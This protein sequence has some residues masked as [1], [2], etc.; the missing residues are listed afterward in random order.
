M[1]ASNIPAPISW[2]PSSFWDGNDGLWNTFVVQVGTPAQDFRV[3]PSTAGQELWIPVPD[4]CTSIS[5]D[6]T[7]Y[8]GYLRGALPVNGVNSSGFTTDD[9]STWTSN[10]IFELN[11]QEEDLGYG[12]N[13]LYGFDTVVWGNSS[14]SP[15]LTQQV[16][17]G[18]ADP[19]WWLGQVGLGPKPI[20]FTTFNYPIPSYLSNLVN[21][22]TIASHSFAYTAGAHHRNQSS[23]SLTLGGYDTNRFEAP[24]ISMAMNGDNS[25]PLQVGVQRIL[26][27]NTLDGTVNLLPTAI[28]HFIDSSV[29]HMWL[30]D[31][32]IDAFV[33]AFGLTYDNETD[34]F[35]IND[36][37]RSQM[38]DLNPTITFVLGASTTG[39]ATD[40]V[41]IELP[42]AALDLQASYP[43][44]ENATNYFPIRRAAN[45]TQY[46]IGRTFLQEAYLIADFE[47]SNF[48]VA[49]AS[50]DNMDT[51]HLVAIQQPTETATP[52]PTSTP[53]ASGGLSGGAIGGIV[54]GAVAGVAIIVDSPGLAEMESPGLA[55]MESPAMRSEV[56]GGT[57]KWGALGVQEL[58]TLPVGHESGLLVEAPGSEGVRAELEGEGGWGRK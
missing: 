52:S 35:L 55:E 24:G 14:D 45:D 30:P 38:L 36:T 27:A 12:G 19:D 40:S 2:A 44:Y 42:Y 7:G 43:F 50:F 9:S 53:E 31:D 8:C 17:A 46:T 10:G 20:N 15:N 49:R 21:E 4:G 56:D 57:A 28:Y 26:A 58:H 16:V 54:V 33:S 48:T 41:S 22:S 37:M 11:A 29:P 18:I 5:P 1:A 3:L 25:R 6:D 51:T 13:G 34:L 47:R 23:A 32:S 39:S